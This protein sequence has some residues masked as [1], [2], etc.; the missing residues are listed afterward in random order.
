[1]SGHDIEISVVIPVYRSEASLAP[2][3][4]RLVVTLSGLTSHWHIVFVEDRGADGSWAVIE[5]LAKAD[6]R[7]TALRLSRNFGQ[8]AAITAGFTF[9]RGRWTVVMDCDLQ[10][11][12][13][14]IGPLYAAAK[15][16][17]DIVFARRVGRTHSRLRRVAARVYFALLRSITG[18]PIDERYGTFSI[19]ASK[20]VNA[21]LTFKDRDRHYLFIL[22]WLGFTTTAI[23]YDQAERVGGTS[24]YSLKRLLAH[25]LAGLFFQTTAILYWIVY[26]GF[27]VSASGALLAAALLY[28]YLA[29]GVRQEGW[30]SLAV[31]MLVLS[32]AMI[33]TTGVIGLY[34]GR[35]FEQVKERPLFV[36]DACIEGDSRS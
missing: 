31:L 9:A 6:S 32:G 28:W 16:G 12:P 26:V 27:A 10:D 36:V 1:V 35:M 25:G 15:A 33:T 13:E 8:H 5:R 21:Y 23:D 22:H 19:V 18:T 29:H 14:V 17:S 20:V 34:I 30:T 24:A 7:V 2:L 11:P 3:Y 4:E